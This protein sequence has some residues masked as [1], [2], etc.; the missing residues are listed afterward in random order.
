MSKHF[1]LVGK[2][3]KHLFNLTFLKFQS[4]DK[5][6]Q[7]LHYW[8]TGSLFDGKGRHLMNNSFLT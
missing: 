8:V 5:L 3:S 6:R 1:L 2:E 4:I 7:I